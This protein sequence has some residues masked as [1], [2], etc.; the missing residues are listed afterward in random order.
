MNISHFQ[1]INQYGVTVDSI[2]IENFAN[3]FNLKTEFY[4]TVD[5]NGDNNFLDIGAHDSCYDKLGYQ[6]Y[7]FPLFSDSLENKT[8]WL[9]ND[10]LNLYFYMCNI[11]FY[12]GE[13]Q[14]YFCKNVMHIAVKQH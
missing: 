11:K 3:I 12:I 8:S 14:P 6:W 10:T 4:C 5:S 2:I 9:H 1:S 7:L 13:A